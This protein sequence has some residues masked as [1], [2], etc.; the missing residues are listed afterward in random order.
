MNCRSCRRTRHYL[1]P[2][3][4]LHDGRLMACMDP[5]RFGPH[6]NSPDGLIP[7]LTSDQKHALQRVCEVARSTELRLKLETGCLLFLN[8]WALLHR[9]DA[10]QDDDRTCRHMVRLWLRNTQLGWAVPEPFLPP[11]QAAYSKGL[12]AKTRVYALYPMTTYVVPKYSAG[13]AA[14]I[15][16]DS[17]DSEPE[18]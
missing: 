16:E 9:R 17:D 4:A 5:N 13:S 2:A 11:W 7:A 6:E 1:A 15:I 14:F 10:Y 8:N 18:R 3:F 12:R